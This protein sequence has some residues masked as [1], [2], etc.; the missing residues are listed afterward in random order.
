MR[1]NAKKRLGSLCATGLLFTGLVGIVNP[2]VAHAVTPTCAT[3]TNSSH[4]TAGRAY[5]YGYFVT[6]GGEFLGYD[7]NATTTL[8]K[9]LNSWD[10][11]NW[12]LD[13]NNL[14]PAATHP[15]TLTSMNVTVSGVNATISGTAADVDGDL[16]KVVVQLG[17]STP[18]NV[19]VDASGNWS[20]TLT[21]LANGSHSVTAK[22]VDVPG[23]QS[24]TQSKT[25]TIQAPTGPVAPTLG[26]IKT[27]VN[28]TTV[29]LSGSA[30]DANGDLDHVQLTLHD[31][32]VV[33]ANLAA[34]GTWT[35][36]ISNHPTGNNFSVSARAFD[37]TGL[38]SDTRTDSY[39]VSG[40]PAC[41]PLTSAQRTALTTGAVN[42]I[43]TNASGLDSYTLTYCGEK[44]A[45]Q[46]FRGGANV[47]H[48]LQSATKTITALGIAALIK[49]KPQLFNQTNP[50]QTKLTDL[51][52]AKYAS[53]FTN[54]GNVNKADITLEN[55]L[56]MT[57][58]L[59]WNDGINTDTEKSDFEEM[60]GAADSVTYILSRPS[61]PTKQKPLGEFFYNT[62]NSHLLSAIIH[63]NT[64][65]TVGATAD[66][67]KQQILTPLGISNFKWSVHREEANGG[68]RTLGDG[69]NEGG[70]ESYFTPS[71]FH[72]LGQ[73][74]L[75]KGTWNGTELVPTSFIKLMTTKHVQQL[76][77]RGFPAD[78]TIPATTP[79]WY[80]FQMWIEAQ[81]EYGL[82]HLTGFRGWGNQDN[83]V[84][85]GNK[86]VLTIT[87][88]VP[89]ASPNYTAVQNLMK[90]VISP[91]FS[92]KICG[93][94][95]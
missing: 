6:T 79:S 43:Q 48:E 25:F 70:R 67:I 76:Y 2:S 80:G 54:N 58:G 50:Y 35:Y 20:T 94:V 9:G 32:S 95:E 55:V 71:D 44:I 29:T 24:T 69:I 51:L 73:L 8:L 64:G 82:D 47:Q 11:A 3:G 26:T 30:A 91:Q 18:V 89:D 87:G 85:K 45:D 33:N 49:T 78:S 28:G 60:D 1:R 92:N 42:W 38:T 83:F 23:N 40:A 66:F 27:S 72:K 86:F 46:Y 21:G 61:R 52:P 39:S 59:S 57:S 84:C 68:N 5:N 62:G 13:T 7:A 36:T 22:A 10:S 65:A 53:L 4:V 93:V 63:Y 31:S 34:N 74:V 88:N 56:T 37:S 81:S 16:A 14:C 17:T 19:T 90:N 75:N 15:P 77:A 41:T 12:Y